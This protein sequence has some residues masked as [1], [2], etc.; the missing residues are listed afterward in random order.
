MAC[1][2]PACKRLQ[3]LV[4]ARLD[5]N[6]NDARALPAARRR[7]AHAGEKRMS[8]ETRHKSGHV[9]G[10]DGTR[11]T[12]DGRPFPLTGVSF[13]NALYNPRFNASLEERRR[14]L[15]TFLAYG[16]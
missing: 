16:V 15:E 1:S 5:G 2:F 6:A 3:G 4:W 10:V 13:F 7:A 14:W 11:I 8:G 12:L 9:V